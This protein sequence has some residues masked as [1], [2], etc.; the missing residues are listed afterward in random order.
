MQLGALLGAALFVAL[1]ADDYHWRVW[2]L[3]VITVFTIISDLTYVD[4]GSARLKVSGS[5]LGLVLAAVILGGG[6]A[7]VVGVLAISVGWLHSRESGHHFRNNLATYAWSPLLAGL[8]FASAI[9]ATGVGPHAIGFYLLVFATYMVALTV[10]FVAVAG[11]TCYVERESL[12]QK[13]REAFVPVLSAQLLSAL[14]AMGA[15]YLTYQL[16]T[17]G[18]AVLGLTFVIFQYLVGELL[19]SQQRSEELQRIVTTDEL[20][21]L[22]NRERFREVM[23]ERIRDARESSARLAVMLMDLDRFK[24]INDTLGHH[25]GDVLLRDLGPRLVEAVGEGG[26]VARLGGDEFGILPPKGSHDIAVMEHVASRLTECVSSP[27]SVDELSLEV[28]VSIGIARFPEDGDDSHALLRCADIA[29]YA[30][31]EAQCDYKLYAADQNQ[32]S[33]RRLSVLSDIRHALASEQIVV[34]YQPIV[35]VDD[36]TVTGAEGLVRWQ[37]PELGLIPPGAFVQTVEQTGLIGPLTRHVLER[38][39]AECAS[40]RKD[41]RD[42]SVAVNLSVR[43]LLDRDLPKEIER[44]LSMY[45]LPAEALELEITESMIMSDPERAMSTVTRLSGLGVR[46]SVDDFGTGYSSLANLRRLPIKDLK[47]DRSFVSP[48]LNDESDLIIVRSTINL[49]HDLGLRVIAEGVEDAA[50][51]RE[52]AHLGCDLAQGYH[53]SRPLAA[54]AFDQWL[55]LSNP[56]YVPAESAPA[57][58]SNGVAHVSNGTPTLPAVH[59]GSRSG[60]PHAPT[61]PVTRRPAVRPAAE[62]AL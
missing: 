20:T 31:K 6:P 14:L 27:F 9:D 57:P 59:G 47:I 3:V 22:A 46:M 54:D 28:G 1:T 26:V 56:R 44:L 10:N 19:K 5:G 60:A 41:G 2:P 30:A 34:H 25:Y 18:L 61:A 51:L 4:T 8:F 12:P 11:Y 40:W 29:M 17:T 15:V 39:I 53:V 32:H 7:A 24:E 52:L 13:T 50:T 36:L 42:L 62:A 37:H 58:A 23:E 55:K 21:G 43:N 16:G 38:S 35:D 49:G 48:M 45:S 33:V